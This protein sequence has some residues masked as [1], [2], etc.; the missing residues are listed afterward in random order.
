MSPKSASQ[1]YLRN[2]FYRRRKIEKILGYDAKKFKKAD[3]PILDIS[4]ILVPKYNEAVEA[5]QSSTPRRRALEARIANSVFAV[6]GSNLPPDATFTL[7]LADGKVTGYKYNG[8]SAPIMTSYYGMYD[9][10]YSNG[11]KFPLVFTNKMAKSPQ[12][13]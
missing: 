8:T 5:F 10:H 7:R 2:R 6:K 1:N 9:R 4:R 13:F 12:E 3:D 11:G